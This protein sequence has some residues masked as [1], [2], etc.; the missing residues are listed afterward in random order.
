MLASTGL[1]PRE[2]HGP[3][4]Y[5]TSHGFFVEFA[6]WNGQEA[7]ADKTLLDHAL[8][9]SKYSM[10]AKWKEFVTLSEWQRPRA[11]APLN[12]RGQ[13]SPSTG[14]A[15][16]AEIEVIPETSNVNERQTKR[17]DLASVQS[18]YSEVDDSEFDLDSY[19]LVYIPGGW[20]TREHLENDTKLHAILSKYC[21]GLDR[22]LG[23]KVLAVSGD[24][25]APLMSV[26]HP[27]TQQP[28]LSMLSSTG[29]GYDSWSGP[30]TG[31][32]LGSRIPK[33]VKSYTNRQVVID[34]KHWYISSPSSAWSAELSASI[35]ALT[36]HAV[37]VDELR[38]MVAAT[39]EHKSRRLT[40]AQAGQL[41]ASLEFDGLTK[42][43]KERL[44]ADG[45]G[46]QNTGFT[47]SQWSWGWRKHIN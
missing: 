37:R 9:G 38:K 15:G 18:Q 7:K 42:R 22:L 4:E 3:W 44:D 30:I 33:L 32:D 19:D 43:Q 16:S 21:L 11:W 35:V 45:I 12:S 41:Q 6:T 14:Q 17:P 31:T 20:A 1:E 46:V 5:L 40:T 26:L 47:L 13:E 8:F 29:P 2:V 27:L 34:T 28:I 24:G 10:Q 39:D 23:A 36:R 25:I